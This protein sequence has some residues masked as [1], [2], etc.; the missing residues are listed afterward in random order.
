MWLR[1][2]GKEHHE[3]NDALTSLAQVLQQGKLAGVDKTAG[4]AAQK[5]H[6][7]LAQIEKV[8]TDASECCSF[9]I[10]YR[11]LGNSSEWPDSGGRERY[12]DAQLLWRKL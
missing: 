12:R 3:I 6:T 11:S 9:A 1:L 7:A 4:E 5:C 2:L 10:G 8:G